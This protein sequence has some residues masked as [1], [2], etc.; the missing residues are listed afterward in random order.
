MTHFR[1]NK[2]VGRSVE[3]KG[4]RAQY[5]IYAILG[6]VL[7]IV[8][9]FILSFI[10]GQTISLFVSIIALVLNVSICFV[11]NN[12]FGEKGLN[13]LYAQ[14]ALPD[15]IAFNKRVCMLIEIKDGDKIQRY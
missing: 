12:R 1:I 10:A 11:L 3:F 15:R 9:F 13:Q 4:L 7:A 8:L 5:F 6:I 2:G 14:K